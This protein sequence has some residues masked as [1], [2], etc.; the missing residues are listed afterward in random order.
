[1]N[2]YIVLLT[3]T[4]AEVDDLEGPLEEAFADGA[5]ATRSTIARHGGRL[6]EIYLTMGQYDG[7]M[8]VEFPDDVSCAGNAGAAQYRW[9]YA[10]LAR[11]SREPVARDRRERRR[12]M[13]M[14]MLS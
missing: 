13:P 5:P 12:L 10:D 1:M 11:L 2:T 6:V 8:I 9:P 7:V 4:S 3:M 14:S